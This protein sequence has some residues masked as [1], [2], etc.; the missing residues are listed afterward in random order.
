MKPTEDGKMDDKRSVSL[1]AVG[2]DRDPVT[3]LRCFWC[4]APL[5]DAQATEVFCDN[6]CT[7]AYAAALGAGLPNAGEVLLAPDRPVSNQA[8]GVCQVRM[9]CVASEHGP[10]TR[11]QPKPE[12]LRHLV[13]GPTTLQWSWQYMY[14]INP[15]LWSD[16]FAGLLRDDCAAAFSGQ[17]YDMQVFSSSGTFKHCLLPDR[18]TDDNRAACCRTCPSRGPNFHHKPTGLKLWLHNG[19]LTN[20]HV[21]YSLMLFRTGLEAIYQQ[22]ME[23]LPDAA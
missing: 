3:T 14:G 12:V 13:L 7:S 15:G 18:A 11:P 10:Y 23:S 6:L 20:A 22:C 1:D 17:G 4:D 2:T 5:R 9:P 16:V 21:N 19:S 8:L